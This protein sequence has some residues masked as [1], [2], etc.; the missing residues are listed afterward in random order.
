[1]LATHIDL[2]RLRSRLRGPLVTPADPAWDSARQAWNLAVDQHPEA[3]VVAAGVDDVVALVDFARAQD[4]GVAVQGTGHGAAALGSLDGTLLLKTTRL[5][6]VDV[7]RS[8]RRAR[9]QAGALWGDVAVAAGRVGLAALHGSSPDVG[10]VGYTLGGGI[11]WLSRLHGLAANSVTAIELVNADGQLLR[12]DADHEPELFWALRG[13]GGAF[14][15]VT[16]VEFELY[17]LESVY[18]GMLAW[19]AELGAE[20]LHAY[21][22]WCPTLPDEMTSIFRFLHLPPLPEVPE[23]LR[24]RPVV[25][26]GAA[27][28]G[29]ADAGAAALRPLRALAAPL[30]DSFATV[31][32]ADLVRL[33][34]D[35]EHPSPG[36]AHHALLRELD[37]AAADAF[38]AAAGPG[39]GSPLISAELRHLGG[40]LGRTQPGAGALDRLDGS[41]VMNAVGVPM[42]PG[43]DAA[44]RAHLDVLHAAL[45]PHATAREYLNFAEQPSSTQAAFDDETWARLRGVKRRVDPA[46]R[47]RSNHPIPA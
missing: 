28:A 40:A 47:F 11:G 32:A 7:D 44:I 1:M 22:E 37:A 27:F 3:V 25:T 12:V 10:V 9:V 13:G 43:D 38:I 21:R 23:P 41:H 35:P 19:P 45:R 34:G 33:H 5:A 14:C 4:V 30:I 17:P 24:G 31:P 16:A 39:S 8:A 18:A 6:R 2:D 36:I 15:V 20:L 42:A 29:A 26:L 46:D